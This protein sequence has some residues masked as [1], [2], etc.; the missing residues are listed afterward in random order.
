MPRILFSPPYCHTKLY[1]LNDR[2]LGSPSSPH[3]FSPNTEFKE[4]KEAEMY[5]LQFSD[6]F[7]WPHIQYFDSAEDLVDKLSRTNLTLVH[8]KMAAAYKIRRNQTLREW[9]QYIPKI[10]KYSGARE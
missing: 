8:E 4:N 1:K 10:Q 2:V 3:P 6:F 9:C 7:D 5:W